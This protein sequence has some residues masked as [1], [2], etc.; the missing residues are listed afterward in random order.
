MFVTLLISNCSVY[1]Y[2]FSV[3]V[4]NKKKNFNLKTKQTLYTASF[5]YNYKCIPVFDKIDNHI[6]NILYHKVNS[7]GRSCEIISFKRFFLKIHFD[8]TSLIFL[9]I[10]YKIY[11]NKSNN[12]FCLGCTSK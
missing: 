4:T 3:F 9:Y 7:W 11:Y 8:K 1:I 2:C 10:T 12:M 5:I 6:A